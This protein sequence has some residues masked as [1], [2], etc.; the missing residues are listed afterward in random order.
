MFVV[1]GAIS[2][3]QCLYAIAG[4]VGKISAGLVAGAK[5]TRLGSSLGEGSTKAVKGLSLTCEKR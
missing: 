3:N 1:V 5:K 4:A 2:K